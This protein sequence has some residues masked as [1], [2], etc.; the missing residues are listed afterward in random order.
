MENILIILYQMLMLI[1]LTAS[2][3]LR[4]FE[5]QK[6]LKSNFNVSYDNVLSLFE[7]R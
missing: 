2:V 5:E 4:A 3:K 1:Y 7:K 6:N